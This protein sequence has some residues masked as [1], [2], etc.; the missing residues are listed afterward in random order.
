MVQDLYTLG[1]DL[2]G[3]AKTIDKPLLIFYKRHMRICQVMLSSGFGGA[4]RLF[5]DACL[6][7]AD[8]GHRILA[9]CHPGFE[10]LSQLQHP[11]IQ[12]FSLT[13]HYDWSYLA[14]VRLRRAMRDFRPQIIHSHLA[15]GAA[16]AGRAGA[17]ENIPIAANLHNYVKLK[18][19]KQISHFIPGTIDQKVYLGRQ[20]V[21]QD[22]IT[23][24][25]HFSRIPVARSVEKPDRYTEDNPPTLLSYGR[26]VKKKGFHILLESLAILREKGLTIHLILGG[27]GPEKK[28]LLQQIADL[29]LADQVELCG[30][31]EDVERFLSRSP[32]FILSSLDEPF[33]IVILE[34]MAKGKIVISTTSQ[35][36]RE[37][38]DDASAY[39]VPT[40]DPNAL[41]G[42]I[43]KA[44]EA[45]EE[46]A[47]KAARAR[48]IYQQTYAPD[49][50]IPMYER[51]FQQLIG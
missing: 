34:A 46:A 35:G 14:T 29:N 31:I 24:I 15:R 43:R 51:A 49:V 42:A 19:Y 4:E 33:G 18:Y 12:L 37:I 9:V 30:W 44:I 5:V 17:A 21:R 1:K 28:N 13:V 47:G 16:V 38:L 45:P 2:Y 41:A 25:P 26:F 32:Y 23:V 10:A 48:D 36:P 20:G 8:R 6:C 22:R 3:D 50:I 7:L 40:D 27:D 39:L 11:N